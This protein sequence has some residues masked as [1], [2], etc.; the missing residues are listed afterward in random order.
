M[1]PDNFFVKVLGKF[2]E[3][4]QVRIFVEQLPNDL[5]AEEGLSIVTS[6]LTSILFEIKFN[7]W[8]I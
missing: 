8:R 7:N 1:I 5:V 4:E 3:K 6:R 2:S